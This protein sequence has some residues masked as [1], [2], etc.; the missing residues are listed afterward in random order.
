MARSLRP[1]SIA[2]RRRESCVLLAEGASLT[3]FTLTN[4]FCD[5]GGG[6]WAS[7]NAFLTNCILTGNSGW[8]GGGICGGIL[9]NC[10]LLGNTAPGHLALLVPLA[11]VV[12]VRT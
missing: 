5:Q 6:V 12:V 1:L 3:G 11:E 9:Y 8:D 10:A 2:R 7:T 4:G